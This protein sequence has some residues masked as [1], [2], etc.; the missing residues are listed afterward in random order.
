MGLDLGKVGGR[1]LQFCRGQLGGTLQLQSFLGCSFP[2]L[3]IFCQRL[4]FEFSLQGVE[5]QLRHLAGGVFLRVGYFFLRGGE[6]ILFD[7]RTLVRLHRRRRQG[8]WL[9]VHL[10]SEDFWD[11]RCDYGVFHW[12]PFI[13]A[14]EQVHLGVQRV[15]E[16]AREAV[17]GHVQHAG[18]AISAHVVRREYRPQR[19]VILLRE[20]VVL[21]VMTPRARQSNPHKGLRGVL[22]YVV[23]PLVA[24]VKIMPGEISRCAQ[25]GSVLRHRLVCR[26]HLEHHTIVFL[27]RIQRL[28]DPVAPM[29]Y[30]PLTFAQRLLVARPVAVAPNVHPVPAPAFAVGGMC[31]QFV[32]HPFIGS[33]GSVLEKRR[34]LF[35]RGRQPD[36]IK[37]NPPQPNIPRRFRTRLQ[38]ALCLRRCNEGINRIANRQPTF[39]RLRHCRP[40]HLRKRSPCITLPK[41][42]VS[43]Q[44]CRLWFD[45]PPLIARAGAG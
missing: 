8:H 12:I 9:D 37:V 18:H 2:F 25:G 19:V 41:F 14:L 29:P 35:R 4:R 6:Q 24:L 7:K 43:R 32:H 33:G 10:T 17:L 23:H 42:V 34:P 22:H 28:H 40:Q 30:V 5:F 27:V 21:V 1:E 3:R 16:R 15:I 13:A 36:E 44:H 31:Q 26:E 38:P 45:R 39:H 11:A 20:R